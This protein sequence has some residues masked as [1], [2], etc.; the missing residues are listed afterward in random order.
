MYVTISILKKTQQYS[1]AILEG[2]VNISSPLVQ[3]LSEVQLKV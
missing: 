1:S 2:I 3:V